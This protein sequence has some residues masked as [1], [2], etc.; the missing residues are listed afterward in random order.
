MYQLK[1]DEN[2]FM[3]ISAVIPVHNTADFVRQSIN[4]LINQTL[5]IAEILVIDDKSTD[6]TL[7]L[8]F[9]EYADNYKVNIISLS[10]N[11]GVSFARNKGVKCCG[12]DWILFMD[13]DDLAHPRLVESLVSTLKECKRRFPTEPFEVVY[14]NY[15]QVDDR[16]KKINEITGAMTLHRDEAQGS[17]FLRNYLTT[18][19]TLINKQLFRSIGGFNE[20][21]SYSEDWDL[22]LRLAEHTG[23]AHCDE[24]LVDVRRHSQNAS[25]KIKNMLTQERKILLTWPLSSI[26]EAIF[27]RKRS[28]CQNAADFVALLFR[29]DRWAEGYRVL[30]SF[31]DHS[32]SASIYFLQGLYYL[33]H[34]QWVEAEQAFLK[35]LELNKNQGAVLNNLGG[36]YL[37]RGEKKKADGYLHKALF[38]HPN[39]MDAEYNSKLSLPVKTGMIHFT[40]RK[41]RKQLTSYT[42]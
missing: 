3:N 6:N 30:S 10:E 29:L 14:P 4:C 21:L 9:K 12:G 2:K 34:N 11:H 1:G 37:L 20:Q 26:K 16:G 24:C 8:L 36:I 18:S 17:L 35:S 33:K 32:E 19:G 22:W 5:S 42:N 38:L 25:A 7:D 13:G 27:R 31:V 41:L 28:R 23:F 39:Y 40:W 15:N